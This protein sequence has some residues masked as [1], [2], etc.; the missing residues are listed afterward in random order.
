MKPGSVYEELNWYK[1]FREHG[2]HLCINVQDLYSYTPTP[3]DKT[4]SSVI[5]RTVWT[6]AELEVEKEEEENIG[7]EVG[8]T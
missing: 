5:G 7:H 1:C 4:P 6:G 8:R 3:V 2:I